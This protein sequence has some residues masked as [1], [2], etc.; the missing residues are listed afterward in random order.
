MMLL[1]MTVLSWPMSPRMRVPVDEMTVAA[2]ALRR[3]VLRALQVVVS[4]GERMAMLFLLATPLLL[5]Q[6]IP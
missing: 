5:T 2:P 3:K 6:Y 4:V 1:P